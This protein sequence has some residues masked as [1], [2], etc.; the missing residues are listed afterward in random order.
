M[1]HLKGAQ[2]GPKENVGEKGWRNAVLPMVDGIAPLSWFI[3]LTDLKC[4][5]GIRILEIV[6]GT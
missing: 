4:T 6:A 5:L 3:N 1:S 2:L